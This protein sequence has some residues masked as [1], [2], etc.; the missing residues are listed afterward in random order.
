[1]RLPCSGARTC[2]SS[3]ILLYCETSG[4]L[5]CK[6]RAS[7]LIFH[8]FRPL[9]M[10]AACFTSHHRLGFWL[11]SVDWGLPAM[12]LSWLGPFAAAATTAVQSA[13]FC[14]PS[15]I[16]LLF[17]GILIT[18][19]AA[20]SCCCGLGWG[21]I[22]GRHAPSGLPAALGAAVVALASRS[23]EAVGRRRLLGYHVQ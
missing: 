3:H 17:L 2:R 16:E 9:A 18:C 19:V 6:L 4:C 8:I 13:T 7:M 1:M 20:C 12:V 23:A 14:R 21:F 10:Q 5:P 11:S 15:G 22:L